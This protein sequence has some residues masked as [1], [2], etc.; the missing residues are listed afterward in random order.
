MYFT[1]YEFLDLKEMERMQLLVKWVFLI[2]VVEICKDISGLNRFTKPNLSYW[3]FHKVI[4][5]YGSN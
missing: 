3:H 4:F 5:S 1:R 2:R